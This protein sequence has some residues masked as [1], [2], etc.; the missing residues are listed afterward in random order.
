MGSQQPHMGMSNYPNQEQPKGAT[1]GQQYQRGYSNEDASLANKF[2]KKNGRQLQDHLGQFQ[3]HNMNQSMPNNGMVNQSQL[4]SSGNQVINGSSQQYQMNNTS[5]QN[6][7]L[8]PSKGNINIRGGQA[9]PQNNMTHNFGRNYEKPS[10]QAKMNGRSNT[11]E[12]VQQDKDSRKN[13]KRKDRMGSLDGENTGN[14]PVG[15]SNPLGTSAGGAVQ[16]SEGGSLLIGPG[17]RPKTSSG[18]H[19]SNLHP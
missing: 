10:K 12:I 5:N 1:T 16:V 14:I 3:N 15:S 17:G 19:T 18:K 13:I 11:I 2:K 8:T 4:G 7:K 9:I 6:R